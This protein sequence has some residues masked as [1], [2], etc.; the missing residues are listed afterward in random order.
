[1]AVTYF[2]TVLLINLSYKQNA[3]AFIIRNVSSENY[4][5]LVQIAQRIRKLYVNMDTIS[6][7]FCPN[8]S[9]ESLVMHMYM[10]LCSSLMT[11]IYIYVPQVHCS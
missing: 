4:L 6:F 3:T 5:T 8:E 1:M 9:V 10:F 7:I 2:T 11:Y